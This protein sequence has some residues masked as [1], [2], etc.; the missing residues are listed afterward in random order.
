MFETTD[1]RKGTLEISCPRSCK[2]SALTNEMKPTACIYITSTSKSESNLQGRPTRRLKGK[3]DLKTLAKSK[4]GNWW[5]LSTNTSPRG[6]S[7]FAAEVRFFLTV[8]HPKP[9]CAAAAMD[10]GHSVVRW[11]WESSPMTARHTESLAAHHLSEKWWFHVIELD[12]GPRRDVN[13]A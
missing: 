1:G 13:Q 8:T 6:F 9:H 12:S 11:C 10:L 3:R 2:C 5:V 7:F 4:L